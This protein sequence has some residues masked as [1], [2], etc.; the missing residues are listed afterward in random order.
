MLK[1]KPLIIAAAALASMGAHASAW[2]LSLADFETQVSFTKQLSFTGSQAITYDFSYTGSSPVLLSLSLGETK[3]GSVRDINF[4]KISISDGSKT[5]SLP[6]VPQSQTA[7]AG[8]GYLTST[9]GPVT[10]FALDAVPFQPH[11]TLTLEGA[12]VG[13][14]PITGSYDLSVMAVPVPEPETYALMLGGLGVFGL[15]RRRRVA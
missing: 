13:T 5:I 12:A 4:T 10:F 14:G 7:L 2:N 11:I 15:L 3:L 6:A 8:G 9:P 1:L